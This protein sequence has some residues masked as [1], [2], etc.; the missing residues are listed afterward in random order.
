MI[1]PAPTRFGRWFWETTARIGI[2]RNFSKVE[3]TEYTTAEPDESIL[4]MGNHHSWWDGF[5][6][7][8]LNKR[9][10]QKNFYVMMLEEQLA[11]RPFMRQT[12]AF[13]VKPGSRDALASVSFAS[14]LCQEKETL[15]VLF[16]QGKIHSQYDQEFQFAAA[17]ERILTNSTDCQP[18]FFASFLDYSS[19]PKPGLFLYT[20]ATTE[21]VH[22]AGA[23]RKFYDK[24]RQDQI[25]RING[26]HA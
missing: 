18:V 8:E 25:R 16:P 23:Y 13:S 9:L 2:S 20:S 14:D 1:K 24:A 3:L 5:W 15:L 4:L 7:M 17:A 11:K 26:Q 22:L 21:R 19:S 12:G 10:W 6:A